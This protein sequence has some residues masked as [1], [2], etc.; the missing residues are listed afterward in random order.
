MESGFH[1]S[2]SRLQR[3]LM[4]TFAGIFCVA[5]LALHMFGLSLTVLCLDFNYQTAESNN[6]SHEKQI[7][8]TFISTAENDSFV[9]DSGIIEGL[10]RIDDQLYNITS[11][12]HQHDTVFVTFQ[13]NESAWQHFTVLSEIMQ[14]VYSTNKTSH[15]VS[16]AIRLLTDFSKVYLSN[17]SF[18]L[19]NQMCFVQLLK[20]ILFDNLQ[21]GFKQ[22]VLLP[23][24]PPPENA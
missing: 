12:V 8:K 6:R 7:I 19:G 11:R 23:D 21:Y 18:T 22:E 24:S 16:L 20:P 13:N 3:S 17:N 14:E 9:K 4:K 5:L 15:P 1:R 10:Y 2:F